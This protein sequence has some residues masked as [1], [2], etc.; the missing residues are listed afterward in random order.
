MVLAPGRFST[1][2]EVPSLGELRRRVHGVRA[3][4]GAKPT[5][6]AAACRGQN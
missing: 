5:I 1:I 4:A 3:A 6:A 2:T